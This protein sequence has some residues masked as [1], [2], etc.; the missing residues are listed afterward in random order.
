MN[1]KLIQQRLIWRMM[2]KSN[3]IM[4]IGMCEGSKSNQGCQNQ[5][6]LCL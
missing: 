2:G 3:E 4:H 1:T 5:L 6:F